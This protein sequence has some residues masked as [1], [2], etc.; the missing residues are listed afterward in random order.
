MLFPLPRSES[1]GDKQ[2]HVRCVVLQAQ[3]WFPWDIRT[4][5]FHPQS[6]IADSSDME[7]TWDVSADDPSMAHPF[8]ET[9][10]W[11]Q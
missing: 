9:F 5:D 8:P 1:Y 2:L 11:K 10:P 4:F 3:I 6:A 7:V